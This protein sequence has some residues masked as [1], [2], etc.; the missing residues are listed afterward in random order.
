LFGLGGIRSRPVICERP[1]GLARALDAL[2]NERRAQPYLYG[3]NDC[4]CF[5]QAAIVAAASPACRAG[6]FDNPKGWLA[7]AKIMIGQGWDS[8]EDV[9]TAAVGTP[10]RIPAGR[11][12]ATSSRTRSGGELH[13]AVRVGDVALPSRPTAN[14]TSSRTSRRSA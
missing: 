4:W 13:L 9:M 7:A 5:A 6:E 2:A 3:K 10:S 1:G 14:T 11:D 12:P 8:V